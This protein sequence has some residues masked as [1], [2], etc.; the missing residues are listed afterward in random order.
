MHFPEENTGRNVIFTVQLHSEGKYGKLFR[1]GKQ[2]RIFVCPSPDKL[3]ASGLINDAHAEEPL[4][5]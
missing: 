1:K 5:S 2:L 3:R 4:R